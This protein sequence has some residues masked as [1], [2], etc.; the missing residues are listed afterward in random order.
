MFYVFNVID[1]SME[2][3]SKTVEYCKLSHLSGEVL[4][5]DSCCIGLPW[6]GH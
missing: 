3:K 2:I 5:L 1:K 6:L 4:Y